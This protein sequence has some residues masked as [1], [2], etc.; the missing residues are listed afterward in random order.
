MVR[1]ASA[2]AVVLLVAVA[3]LVVGR[4][5]QQDPV[6]PLMKAPGWREALGEPLPPFAVIEI[7]YD[8]DTAARAWRENTDSGLPRR[9]GRP[10]EP[11]IYGDL[12]DVDF[13]THAV[14]VWSSGESSS[15]PE[16]PA[17]LRF[18]APDTLV[19]RLDRPGT[20]RD[21]TSD[22]APYRMLAVVHREHL[23][24]PDRLSSVD[25]AGVP[26]GGGGAVVSAYPWER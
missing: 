1:R 18:H 19:V 21:C 22:Y 5:L 17:N 11:G 26:L 12:D 25:V 8:R 4:S 16:W 3:T 10:V 2:V 6:V 7:A 20:V 14:V 23:P 13:T 15:C 9:T 24:P